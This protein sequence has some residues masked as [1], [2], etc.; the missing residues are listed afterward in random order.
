MPASDL[1]SKISNM[2]QQGL[3]N[4]KIIEN[5]KNQGNTSQEI[6]DAM[7]SS[8][9][10]PENLEAPSPSQGMQ[11]SEFS[12]ESPKET[13]QKEMPQTTEMQK[14]EETFQQPMPQAQIPSR[15]SI[16]NIEEIAES[17]IEEK[18]N[19]VNATLGDINM[20]K[21]KTTAEI[22]AIKQEILRLRNTFENLQT[23]V[24]GKVETYNRNIL[25]MN[26]E[27][28]ALSKVFEKIIQPLTYNIKE[29]SRITETLKK[30]K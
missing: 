6:Y 15:Q 28:K 16:E 4:P 20:W 7:S 21:E 11:V 25:D 24:L 13:P 2:Q 1:S 27:I 18:W 5:L 22:E 8:K 9:I 26:T 14:P 12:Q 10:S 29:L 3:S 23:V 19:E 17:I 30:N